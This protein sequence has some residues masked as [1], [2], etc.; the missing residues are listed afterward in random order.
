MA[1]A[2]DGHGILQVELARTLCTHHHHRSGTVRHQAAVVAAQGR[3]DQA[4]FAVLLQ[5]EGFAQLGIRVQGPVLAAGHSDGTE[6]V[7]GGAVLAHVAPRNHGV[8][9]R[10]AEPT[11]NAVFAPGLVIGL[12]GAR[13]RVVGQGDDRDVALPGLDGH[14]GITNH[15]G[16]GGTPLVPHAADARH[17]AQRLGQLLGVHHFKFGGRA[18]D[19]QAVHLALVHA[20][21]GQGFANRLDIQR[22]GAAPSQLAKRGV[23][24]AGDHG[25]FTHQI[26]SSFSSWS[27]SWLDRPSHSP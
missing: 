15:A 4:R 5:G 16:V 12:A 21:I 19:E 8:T 25:F 1:K 24:Y 18:L 22:Q 9:R 26:T 6:L 14:G 10:G 27:M 2:Q 7:A 3:G 11:K 17:D 23:P 20:G 13:R